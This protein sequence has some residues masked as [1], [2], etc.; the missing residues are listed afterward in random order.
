MSVCIL[1]QAG[2]ILVHR[3]MK[4]SPETFL[5]TLMPSR[6]AI[7]VA[8]EGVVTWYWLADLCA[9]EGMPFV[10]GH[11]RSMQAIHG[12]KA[13]NDTIDA[14]TMAV[15]L[16]GGMLPQAYVYPAKRR[17][18]RALLRRRLYLTRTRA[19]W[20]AHMQNTNR[21]DNW[22]ESGKKVASKANRDGVAERFPAP[23]VPKS[24]AVD[25]ALLGDDDPL[26]NA[27]E[28]HIGTAAKQHDAQTLSRLQTVPGIGTRLRL[29][30]LDDMHERQRFPR[31]QDCVS[32][33]RLG[34]WAQESAGKR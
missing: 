27:L 5:Q 4:A 17:A 33:C 23:A 2:A 18:P 16:R 1:N 29:V 6:E 3:T 24:M 25:R 30:L 20:L 21:Q 11:A 15:L 12:G 10:R 31:V 7:V 28:T 19:E 14:P 34:K 22:P 9:R 8:V 26:R 13:N 32:S